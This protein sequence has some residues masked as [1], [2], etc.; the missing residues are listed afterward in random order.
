MCEKTYD[1]EHPEGHKCVFV[2]PCY[3]LYIPAHCDLQQ[4]ATVK[5]HTKTFL[6]HQSCCSSGS[7]KPLLVHLAL[8]CDKHLA[9][10][11]T[12]SLTCVVHV[13]KKL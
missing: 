13:G 7:L 4:Y 5:R 9:F 10:L 2:C 11:H 12:M 8:E 3:I 1:H 6:G